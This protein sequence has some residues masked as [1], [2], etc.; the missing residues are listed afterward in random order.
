[1]DSLAGYSLGGCVGLRFI[2]SKNPIPPKVGDTLAFTRI[3]KT[4]P[5]YI[6]Y[7]SATAYS[8]AFGWSLFSNFVESDM[9]A[10][11]EA[12]KPTE[13]ITISS[14]DGAIHIDGEVSDPVLI[15]DLTG[16]IFHRGRVKN[17]VC[18]PTSGMYMVKI[19]NRQAQKVVVR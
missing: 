10:I 11:D 9:T 13:N 2:R 4:I 3:D 6:P 19:G 17:P 16:R 15:Y 18:V 12:T 14:R 8:T 7:G 1:M 5:V